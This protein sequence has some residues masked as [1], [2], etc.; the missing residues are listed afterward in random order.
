MHYNKKRLLASVSLVSFVNGRSVASPKIMQV[1]F[2]VNEG[3]FSVGYRKK[4]GERDDLVGTNFCR[5]VIRN[6]CVP[7]I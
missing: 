3:F 5:V 4:Q 6:F 1:Q 2:S 7:L